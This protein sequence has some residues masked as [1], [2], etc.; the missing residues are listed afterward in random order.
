VGIGGGAGPVRRRRRPGRRLRGW[1]SAAAG[2]RWC[3][4]G[5]LPTPAC[6][7]PTRFAL[8]ATVFGCAFPVPQYLQLA[9][10][11]PPAA[12][13]AGRAAVHRPDDRIG[14]R[15]LI[16]AGFAC[17][18]G[19]LARLAAAVAPASSYPHLLGPLLL[20]G[21][22]VG[23][24]VPTTVSASLR[25]PRPAGRTGQRYRLHLPE[26]RRGLRRRHRH[27]DLRHRR[28]LPEP[29]RLHR[30]AAA[31]PAG[32][33]RPGRSRIARRP[34]DQARPTARSRGRHRP[35]R[36]RTWPRSARWKLS[37]LGWPT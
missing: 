28:Q 15:A 19:G 25:G 13:R 22:G 24:A 12:H 8:F 6:P 3:R 5:C 35:T 1:P 20:A 30:R 9:H 10:G 29:G 27:R 17:D 4:C 18:A 26:R 21:T 2:S 32:P 31:H 37:C 33:R 36:R 34:D 23:L 14:E 16:L 11:F 7:G